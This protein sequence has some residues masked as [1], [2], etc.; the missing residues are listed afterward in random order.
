MSEK[1]IVAVVVTYNRKEDLIN[2]LQSIFNQSQTVDALYIIDNKST[3]G[4][5]EYLIENKIIKSLPS[6]NSDKD[7]IYSENKILEN[8]K[9]FTLH[10]I[11]KHTNDG[12]AGGF[13]KG[14]K[15]AYESNCDWL[16]LMDD[17]G[18][19]DKEQL[20]NLV[21]YSELYKLNYVNALVIDIDDKN[22]LA[23]KIK[24]YESINEIKEKEII[25]G[26]MSPF[27]GTLISRKVIDKIGLIKK[28]MFIWGDE[29]EYTSRVRFNGFKRVTI[30]S[31]KH[32]HP[33]VKG[34]TKKVFPFIDKYKVI[35]KPDH[36]A[37]VFYRNLGYLDITY[38]NSKIILGSKLTYGLYFL[39]RLKFKS[40]FKF[41]K[42]YNRGLKNN[43]S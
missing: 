35:I 7:E 42:Y 28:E 43:Y 2:C 39:L 30:I 34:V 11:R 25:E 9:E 19:A 26:F 40:F 1:R 24:G 23:F 37:H 21:K 38:G 41:F 29:R 31:A 4:T 13:Y 6:F 15:L 33:K 27:N 22:K 3:D 10:Y 17:D 18:V 5:P 12:G 16:W 36:F 20:K 32:F 8:G 14:M